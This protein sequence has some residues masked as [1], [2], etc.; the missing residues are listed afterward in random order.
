M[1]ETIIAEIDADMG[2]RSIEGIEEDQVARLKFIAFERLGELADGQAVARQLHAGG[3][4]E[5]MADEAA[6]VHACLGRVTAQPVRGAHQAQGV[7]RHVVARGGVRG[8]Q[9]KCEEQGKQQGRLHR[10]GANTYS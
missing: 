1:H 10:S 6:T 5:N 7:H 4:T 2:I 9:R 3:L 8:R